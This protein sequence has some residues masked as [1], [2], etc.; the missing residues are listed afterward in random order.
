LEL[1][2]SRPAPTGP[3]PSSRR[4]GPRATRMMATRRC[5]ADV[6]LRSRKLCARLDAILA[7]AAQGFCATV[8]QIPQFRRQ[9][10]RQPRDHANGAADAFLHAGAT[11]GGA[12]AGHTAGEK[13]GRIHPRR[14]SAGPV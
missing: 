10:A 13:S 8:A 2:P 5:F 11:C 12:C 14:Q 7:I 4:S 3:P 6:Q 1:R 9:S